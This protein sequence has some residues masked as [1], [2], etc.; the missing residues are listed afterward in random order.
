VRF[1]NQQP[2]YLTQS[3]E[4]RHVEREKRTKQLSIAIETTSSTAVQLV[5]SSTGR[6]NEC[7]TVLLATSVEFGQHW[8]GRG[9]RLT[10]GIPRGNN[11]VSPGGDWGSES[12]IDVGRELHWNDRR[13]GI[14]KEPTNTGAG[15]A[16]SVALMRRKRKIEKGS[17]FTAY[18]V[19]GWAERRDVGDAKGGCFYRHNKYGEK[20]SSAT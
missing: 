12:R 8:V 5:R 15:G 20:R 11:A 7:G 18:I 9:F 1:V 19:G 6:T 3:S 4:K 10:K 14:L 16:R 13:V 17:I 2:V